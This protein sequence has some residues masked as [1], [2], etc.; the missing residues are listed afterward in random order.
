MHEEDRMR[1]T[2]L[3]IAVVAL[4]SAGCR[5][6]HIIKDFGESYRKSFEVQQDRAKEPRPAVL[7]L[8]AQ[9]AAI[10]ANNYRTTLVPEG[11]EAK[12]EPV[13]IVA[14]PSRERKEP[15]APSVPKE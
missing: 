15:L 7:G 9:E 3:L 11:K 10:T 14:P 5:Q 12:T 2:V 13:V 1:S 6:R 4:S 8:D